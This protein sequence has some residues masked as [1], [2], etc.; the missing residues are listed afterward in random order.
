MRLTVNS[1]IERQ[2]CSTDWEYVDPIKA[3]QYNMDRKSMLVQPMIELSIY[4]N[5]GDYFCIRC[6]NWFPN[7]IEAHLESEKHYEQI[8]ETL[9]I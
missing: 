6:R 2:E 8:L 1:I 9:A 4:P 5:K 7:S 3:E